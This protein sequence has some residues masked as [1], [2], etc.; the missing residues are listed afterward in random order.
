MPA[1]TPCVDCCTTPQTV[2]IPGSPGATGPAGTNG[3]NGVN[4]YTT[5]T[6][7]FLTPAL[8]GSVTIQVA[9]STWMVVGQAL[10]VADST[11][12]GGTYLV[13]SVPD[14]THV[15]VTYQNYGTNTNAGNVVNSGAGVAAGGLQTPATSPLPI[16]NGGTNATTK[17]AAQTSL[18][19]GQNAVVSTVGPLTQAITGSVTAVAGCAI[20]ITAAGEWLYSGFATV[21]WASTIVF[22]APRVVTLKVRNITQGVDL[23]SNVYTTQAFTGVVFPSSDL[24]IPFKLDATAIAADSI[25]LFIS[26]TTAGG[27]TLTGFTCIA[28]SLVGIPLRLT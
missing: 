28:G 24:H 25:G 26:V 14:S 12:D 9:N 20:S 3:T 4:A 11:A 21:S 10:V 17:A 8:A 23:A 15:V 7:N 13:T 5:T 18:G 27:D 6:D 16:A 2:N 1:T 19:L 22:A